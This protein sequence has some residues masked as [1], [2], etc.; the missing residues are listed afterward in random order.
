MERS[1]GSFL[2]IFGGGLEEEFADPGLEHEGAE[3]KAVLGEGSS[4][5]FMC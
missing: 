1:R 3:I 5:S 2:G 4:G